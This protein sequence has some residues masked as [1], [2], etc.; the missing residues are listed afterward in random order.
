MT[1]ATKQ[2]QQSIWGLLPQKL[3]SLGLAVLN[4]KFILGSNMKASI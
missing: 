1:E 2:Q 4:P 3:S